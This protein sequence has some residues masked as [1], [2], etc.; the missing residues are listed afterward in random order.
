M[1]GVLNPVGETIHIMGQDFIVHGVLAPTQGGLLSV[2]QA[3]YNSSVFVTTGD[4]DKLTSNHTNILQILARVKPGMNVDHADKV[5]TDILSRNHGGTEDFTVLKP[6][7]LIGVSSQVLNTITRFISAIAAI[8]LVVGGIGIM[9]IM[10]VSVSE[11]TRE[12]GI[13]KA[14][15]ATNRQIL[16]QFLV[17]GLVLT[18][19]GGILGVITSLALNLLLRLYSGWKP[20]VSIPVILLAV[21]VSIAAGLIFS[22]IPALK[23]ARKDPITAL[24]GE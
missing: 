14:V 19:S 24:R 8:S 1:F 4:A 5:L 10:L 3:D 2:A 12:I 21:G 20:V 9:N 17:E 13:R 18:V 15:G 23:A 6:D 22:L 7:Q 16:H 11:R